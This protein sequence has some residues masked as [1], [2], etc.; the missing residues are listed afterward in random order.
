MACAFK[1][2]LA[3]LCDANFIIKIKGNG[4]FGLLLAKTIPL[5]FFYLQK[6][7]KRDLFKVVK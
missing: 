2:P 3:W 5:I 1:S 6:Q 7:L 4:W